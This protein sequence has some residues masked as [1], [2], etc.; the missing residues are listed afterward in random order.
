MLE[1]AAV[2]DFP[3][4]FVK[5][6]LAIRRNPGTHAMELR[7]RWLGFD[8]AGDT[9]EPVAS[10][11]ASCPDKVEAFLRDDGGAEATRLLRRYF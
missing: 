6:L 10:L 1:E 7:V 11:M 9:W 3:D 4:N 2:R 5:R 8:V